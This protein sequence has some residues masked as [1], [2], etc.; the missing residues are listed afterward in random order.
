VSRCHGNVQLLK[1]QIDILRGLNES[2][3]RMYE[4]IDKGIIETDRTNEQLR[5]DNRTLTDRVKTYA[6][7]LCEHMPFISLAS[8]CQL[9][10]E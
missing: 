1:K 5:A 8:Q 3:M 6:H 7:F 2:R 4:D 9:I 10:L